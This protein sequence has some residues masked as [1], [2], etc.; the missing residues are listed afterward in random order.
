MKSR[1]KTKSL[2]TENSI[3][4]PPKRKPEIMFKRN[5]QAPTFHIIKCPDTLNIPDSKLTD[6]ESDSHSESN[7]ELG[8]SAHN[9]YEHYL[10]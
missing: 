4:N 10:S 2:V 8:N 5:E 3:R 1:E 6:N 7:S 9:F